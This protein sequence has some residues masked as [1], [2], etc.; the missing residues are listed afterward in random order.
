[1]TDTTVEVI[2]ARREHPKKA[3]ARRP[4][5]PCPCTS[6]RAPPENDHPRSPPHVG[7]LPLHTKPRQHTTVSGCPR[8]DL[9]PLFPGPK[10]MKTVGPNDLTTLTSPRSCLRCRGMRS[11]RWGNGYAGG[12]FT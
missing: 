11:K 10:F 12:V 1:M 6:A 7:S 8:C 9:H 2:Q 4:P 3:P 5:I